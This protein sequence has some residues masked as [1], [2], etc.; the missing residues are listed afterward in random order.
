[1]QKYDLLMMIRNLRCRI[2]R[3]KEQCSN[4]VIDVNGQGLANVPPG[5]YV[6]ITIVDEEGN[7]VPI[8]SID[9][10]IIT[11]A[12]TTECPEV[13]VTLTI[14][15]EVVFRD[16]YASGEDIII[17][18]DAYVPACSP[19]TYTIKLDGSEVDSGSIPCG[20]EQ[21]IDITSYIPACDPATARINDNE[22]N[23]ISG[24]TIASGATGSLLSPPSG[25]YKSGQ[26]TVY[27][28]ADT[29]SNA[30]GNGADWY[31]L[32]YDNIFGN[33]KAYTGTTG[34]YQDE[35]T[36]VYHQ[37]NGTVIGIGTASR[38]IAFPNGIIINWKTRNFQTGQVYG[39]YPAT[40]EAT[41]TNESRVTSQGKIDLLN[42]AGFANWF[43]PNVPELIQWLNY[44][45]FGRL[46]YRPLNSWSI[47]NT[48]IWTRNS[49]NLTNAIRYVTNINFEM[50]GNIDPTL[51]AGKPF[52]LR[53]FTIN[54][55]TLT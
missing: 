55:T 6:P 31:N 14:E 53:L 10:T 50:Q 23:T 3:L 52:P 43:M 17:P 24:T 37:A 46:D 21:E 36:G 20:T 47:T 54:G 32:G 33:Q 34:G 22:D 38:D 18:I 29:A 30:R 40:L 5:T 19:A 15:E 35:T 4:V 26:T 49:R 11:I 45:G 28:P 25:V 9:G 51:N 39:F 42:V 44:E 8:V 16:C 7:E 13:C 2:T 27:F 48:F 12:G 41:L 1:M